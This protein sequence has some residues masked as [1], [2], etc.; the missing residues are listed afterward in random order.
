MAYLF[1]AV[2]SAMNIG[3]MRTIAR[4][5]WLFHNVRSCDDIL[6]VG[7]SNYDSELELDITIMSAFN[8]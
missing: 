8:K 4:T 3:S 7:V 2:S 1:S 6:N 5:V